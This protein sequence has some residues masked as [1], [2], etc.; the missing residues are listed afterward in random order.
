MKQTCKNSMNIGMIYAGTVLGAGFA[1]GQEILSFFA[2][3]GPNGMWGVLIAGCLFILLG[4][5]ILRK[6][7]QHNLTSYD[8]FLQ[9]TLPRP[10]VRPTSVIITLFLLVTYVAMISGSGA[11]VRERFSLPPIAGILATSLLCF[12]VFAGSL[13]GVSLLNAILTPTMTAGMLWVSV[14]LLLSDTAT[15]A[16]FGQAL[17]NNH[18]ASAFSYVGFNLLTASVMLV[19]LRPML[20]NRRTCL[21][22]AA[23]G[24]GLLAACGLLAYLV[25]AR[26]AGAVANSQLPLFA[27]SGRLGSWAYNAYGVVLY[28]ARITTAVSVGFGLLQKITVTGLSHR[29][30]CLL[31]CGGAI[32]FSLIRFDVMVGTFYTLFG[33]I[34]LVLLFFVLWLGV[35]PDK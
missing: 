28:I 18:I 11:L 29:A 35:R 22:G 13:K 3:F 1:S 6:T 20:N 12:V 19:S 17:A 7:Y 24:G 14:S 23:V 4:H 21:G 16:S 5:I 2:R 10:L 25:L 34:G 15:M 30:T 27:L 32:P 8:S 31:L 9:L 26:F 33:Y